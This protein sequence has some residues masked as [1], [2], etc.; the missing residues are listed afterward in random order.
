VK[1]FASR[2]IERRAEKRLNALTVCPGRAALEE[3]LDRAKCILINRGKKHCNP[4]GNK[5]Y[6]TIRKS[7]T[8]TKGDFEQVRQ[9]QIE[10]ILR[11]PFIKVCSI[12]ITFSCRK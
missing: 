9:L 12:S 4:L 7:I 2:S 11:V 6:E 10:Y 1:E 8:A 5:N 3:I